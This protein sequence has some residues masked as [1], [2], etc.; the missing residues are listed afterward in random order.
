MGPLSIYL[1]AIDPETC[2]FVFVL[3]NAGVHHKQMSG[4]RPQYSGHMH[5]LFFVVRKF[6]GVVL[7][8]IAVGRAMTVGSFFN[9]GVF[10]VLFGRVFFFAIGLRVWHRRAGRAD[11]D[12]DFASSDSSIRLALWT[13]TS[14]VDC[15]FACFLFCLLF[16]SSLLV[17]F[18]FLCLP[19]RLSPACSFAC[20][21]VLSSLPAFC[22]FACLS[23]CLPVWSLG[24]V[25]GF[26]VFRFWAFRV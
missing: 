10:D 20:S 18:L 7:G 24:W 5:L 12:V 16:C 21:F 8:I 3:L 23:F 26:R 6:Q 2:N 22:S 17:C 13:S 4:V 19:V 15:P 9:G 25:R 14:S 11:F 1:S